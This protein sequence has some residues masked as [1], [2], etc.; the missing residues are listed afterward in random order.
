MKKEIKILSSALLLTLLGTSASANGEVNVGYT[1][2]SISGTTQSGASIG[3]GASFGET[4]KQTVGMKVAF[5]GKGNDANEDKGNI[6]DIYYNIGYEVLPSTVAYA[7]VGYGFQSLGTVGTG[8]NSTTAYAGG[9][10]SGAGIK[11]DINK[12]FALDLSYKNYALSYE[13]LDYDAKVTNLSLV[14]TLDKR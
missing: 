9:L 1:S 7:S 2:A 14:Y 11:Y 10:T 12:K 8:S 6:G 3:Y 5:L 13:A 4:I